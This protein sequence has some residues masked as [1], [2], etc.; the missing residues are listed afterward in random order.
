MT[1]PCKNC[2]ER[3]AGCHTRCPYGKEW[4]R[5]EQARR[6]KI[7]AAKAREKD[8]SEFK[9]HSVERTKRVIGR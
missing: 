5:Q 7:K 2:K 1:N 3:T 4:D 8:Y 6:D 9:I